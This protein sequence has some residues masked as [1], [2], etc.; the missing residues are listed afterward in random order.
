MSIDVS[1]GLARKVDT[2]GGLVICAL[3]YAW[4]RL[5]ARLGGPP[6]PSMYA[7]TPPT[8]T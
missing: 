5:R 7:T 4:G 8:G 6:L 3:L 1:M 2:L